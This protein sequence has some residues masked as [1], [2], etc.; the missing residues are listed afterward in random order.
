VA[1]GNQNFRA[2][3]DQ[4]MLKHVDQI[5]EIGNLA[6]NEFAIENKLEKTLRELNKLKI[7][8]VVEPSS[9]K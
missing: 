6:T 1:K 3:L 4:G 5:A 9:G 2:L 7:E 8:N